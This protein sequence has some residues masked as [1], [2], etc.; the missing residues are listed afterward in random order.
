MDANSGHSQ[1]RAHLVRQPVFPSGWTPDLPNA[2]VATSRFGTI[3]PAL[4]LFRSDCSLHPPWNAILVHPV[5]QPEG[6]APSVLRADC[7]ERLES[8]AAAASTAGSGFWDAEVMLVAQPVAQLVA[9]VLLMEALVER[10][11]LLLVQ[12]THL[13]VWVV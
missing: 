8:L 10:V 13:A 2:G 9:M 4:V 7:W 3:H 11:E 6:S 5:A 1:S 12:R